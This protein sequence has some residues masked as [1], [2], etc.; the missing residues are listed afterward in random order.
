MIKIQVVARHVTSRYVTCHF[1]CHVRLIGCRKPICMTCEWLTD[2][3]LNA[4]NGNEAIFEKKTFLKFLLLPRIIL[5]AFVVMSL[6]LDDNEMEKRH[7][8]N[9]KNNEFMY[10]DPSKYEMNSVIY[11]KLFLSQ[12]ASSRLRTMAALSKFWANVVRCLRLYSILCAK[13]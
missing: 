12:N 10:R 1:V 7:R 4:K 8:G 13:R 2:C 5:I 6:N 3:L 11:W 9:K